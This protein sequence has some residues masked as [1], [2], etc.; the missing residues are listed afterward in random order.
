MIG[1]V[2]SFVGLSDWAEGLNFNS[3]IVHPAA[4][5]LVNGEPLPDQ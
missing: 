3:A 1:A 5:R 2:K 4:N